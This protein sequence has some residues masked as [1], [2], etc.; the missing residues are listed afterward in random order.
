[1][2]EPRVS[3][4]IPGRNCARTIRPSLDACQV[5]RTR[6]GSLLEEI[7]FV[8]DGSTDE[9]AK[10]VAE[11]DVEC[12]QSGGLGPGAARNVGW[13]KARSALVWFIDS[14]C[15]PEPDAL[16][17]LLPHIA[18][19]AVAGAGGSYGNVHKNVLLSCLIHEEIVQRHKAMMAEV[20]FLGGF[21]VL[22]R[23]A[24]LLEVGGF[25]E[26]NYCGPGSPGAE[27]ADLSY[28]LHAAGFRL[29]FEP[30]SLVGHH[31]PTSLLRY[32]RSQRHHGYWR[33]YLH[34]HHR[35]T[36][37]GDAYSGIIDHAQPF[38]ALFCL[39]S[40]LLLFRQ[41]YWPSGVA[42]GL[43]ILAQLPMTTRLVLRTKK[44]SYLA[45]APL[46]F[47]RAFWRAVGM[48][49]GVLAYL[50]RPD[51]RAA[52]KANGLHRQPGRGNS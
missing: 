46:G 15:I 27:D 23:R 51:R 2:Q 4:V 29:R 8:D 11:F 6:P 30:R 42:A 50:V 36:S 17:L 48:V 12:T 47:V 20:N 14:D 3:L 35:H 39:A 44:L 31:H 45:F 1:M 32:L 7:I 26:C 38:L 22:Y 28:R 9:T 21:N 43:L 24:A 16:E 52:Q 49:Q 18:L 25:D 41:N 33:V 10:I 13:K 40:L 37:T 19:P 34:M 5:I